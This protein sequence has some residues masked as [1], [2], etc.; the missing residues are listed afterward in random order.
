MRWGLLKVC[1]LGSN[2]GGSSRGGGVAMGA[3]IWG[4]G[5]LRTEEWEEKMLLGA[6][7][8]AG[9]GG[10]WVGGGGADGKPGSWKGRR[11]LQL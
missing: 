8:R 7:E 1:D 4:D 5:M 2:D 3:D 9:G 6:W 10:N 11:N